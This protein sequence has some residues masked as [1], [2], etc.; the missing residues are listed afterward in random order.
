M[1]FDQKITWRTWLDCRC[2]LPPQKPTTKVVEMGESIMESELL[3]HTKELIFKSNSLLFLILQCQRLGNSKPLLQVV[4]WYTYQ[5]YSDIIRHPSS[6][7]D[8]WQAP[9]CGSHPQ[10]KICAGPLQDNVPSFHSF[11]IPL[12][13][14]HIGSVSCNRHPHSA[15]SPRMIPAADEDHDPP[16]ISLQSMQHPKTDMTLHS[17]DGKFSP[18]YVGLVC[19]SDAV[20][21]RQCINRSRLRSWWHD[22]MPWWLW[23]CFITSIWLSVK[24]LFV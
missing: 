14:A 24:A 23:A 10:I 7:S 6:V 12:T 9:E 22:K 13:W 8:R 15:G 11:K 21:F 16:Q 18:L 3:D 2:S 19:N 4:W 5:L 20:A 17:I 1:W